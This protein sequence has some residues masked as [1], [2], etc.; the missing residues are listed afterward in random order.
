VFLTYINDD[1]G[2]SKNSEPDLP[3][4]IH[5]SP[6]QPKYLDVC[7]QTD[8]KGVLFY[9]IPTLISF[10]IV[11]SLFLKGTPRT[12]SF[13]PTPSSRIA[14]PKRPL[15]IQKDERLPG[16]LTLT[17][18]L[19]SNHPPNKSQ[20]HPHHIVTKQT[21]INSNHQDIIIFHF[22]SSSLRL[23]HRIIVISSPTPQSRLR[24]L[25]T[26]ISPLLHPQ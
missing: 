13:Y 7:K 17:F 1:P 11:S 26:L 23:F 4:S 20:T 14:F 16:T 8:K 21:K 10:P 15:R 18:P 5:S 9:L 3:R 12:P 25:K 19:P 22:S 6:L 24:C 2:I